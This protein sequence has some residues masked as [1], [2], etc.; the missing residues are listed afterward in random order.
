MTPKTLTDFH[1][2]NQGKVSDKWS[3]YLDQYERLFNLL[4]DKA[5]SLFEIGIQNGGPLQVWSKY[6]PRAKAFV[7][8]DI[9]KECSILT[10]QDPRINLMMATLIC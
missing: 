8:C 3:S 9:N 2:K 4:R 1:K 10:Y 6:F 5:I 7:G